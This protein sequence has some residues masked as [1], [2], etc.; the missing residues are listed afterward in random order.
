[1]LKVWPLLLSTPP[2]YALHCLL[3][4]EAEAYK[5]GHRE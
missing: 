4:D 2:G 1:M 3:P 5:E